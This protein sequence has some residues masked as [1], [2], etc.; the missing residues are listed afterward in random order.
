MSAPS[1]ALNADAL[2]FNGVRQA[3]EPHRLAA[4]AALREA[5]ASRRYN[6]FQL[7][8]RHWIESR[9]WRN[10]LDG[11]PLARLME[12]AP[13]FA[14]RVLTQLRRKTLKR[15]A[16]FEH[17]HAEA[18]HDVRIAVKKLRYAAEF[19]HNLFR[20]ND[21]AEEFTG[22]LAHL[23]G[24]L[25]HDSDASTTWPLLRTIAHDSAMPEVQRAV[26]VV[27]GWQARD[28]IASGRRLRK[29]WRQFENMPVFWRD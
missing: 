28:R 14:S 7:S 6:R 15:G 8:V 16:H 29:L 20:G 4:Y 13:R 24:A 22:C 9:S 18:R 5:L 21:K 12:P 11:R 2:D 10:E 25:G 1:E 3:A 26:G 23:Q 19:F 27:I 17:L